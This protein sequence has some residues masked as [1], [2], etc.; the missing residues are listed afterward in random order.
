MTTMNLKEIASQIENLKVQDQLELV[1]QLLDAGRFKLASK[2]LDKVNS[3]FA[4]YI[5][6]GK[7]ISNGVLQTVQAHRRGT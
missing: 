5:N 6:M 3:E 4:I 1:K 2:I 7:I